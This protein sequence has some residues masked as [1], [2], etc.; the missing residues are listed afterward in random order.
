MQFPHKW[1]RK[2]IKELIISIFYGLLV[3]AVKSNRM[4]SDKSMLSYYA[5]PQRHHAYEVLQPICKKILFLA[6]MR[7]KACMSLCWHGNH[8][9]YLMH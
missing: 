8:T 2:Q 3:V 9:T 1:L 7:M 5:K 6:T 4:N